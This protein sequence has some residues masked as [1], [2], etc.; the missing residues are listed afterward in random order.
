MILFISYY[1]VG[2]IYSFY[3]REKLQMGSNNL[4]IVGGLMEYI[5]IPLLFPLMILFRLLLY[6][7]W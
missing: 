7:Q 6:K 4:T 3:L 1:L 5:V 2:L